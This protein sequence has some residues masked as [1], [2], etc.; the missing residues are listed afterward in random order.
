MLTQACFSG[1]MMTSGGYPFA[2]L[3]SL[4]EGPAAS[5]WHAVEDAMFDGI[6]PLDGQEANRAGR[7]A[8]LFLHGLYAHCAL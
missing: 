7:N 1:R 5:S 4:A 8:G 3:S 2:A 6:R